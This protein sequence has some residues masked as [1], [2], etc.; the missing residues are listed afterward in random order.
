ML[1]NSMEQSEWDHSHQ[2]PI[3]KFYWAVGCSRIPGGG[4][5]VLPYISYIG[6]CRCEGYGF[7][8]VHSRI[9]YRNQRGLV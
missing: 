9:G 2:G 4:G 5:V 8:R 3:T 7:Q 6:M 1:L